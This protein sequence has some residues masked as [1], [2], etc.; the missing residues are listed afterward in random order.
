MKYKKLMILAI[1]LVSLLAIS[2]V[3]AA[4]NATSDVVSVEE[5]TDKVVSVEENQVIEQTDEGVIGEVDNGT[6]KALRYKID[7]AISGSTLILENDYAFNADADYEL[8]WMGS[9]GYYDK[10]LQ[11]SP[12]KI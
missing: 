6:F 2:A 8:I 7:N 10:A 3:N 12:I 11:K 9:W 4:D 5:T 1:F